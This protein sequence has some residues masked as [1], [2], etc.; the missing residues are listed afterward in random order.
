MA[1]TKS[2]Y[3]KAL[4]LLTLSLL[5]VAQA[6]RAEIQALQAQHASELARQQASHL[7]LTR[8]LAADAGKELQRALGAAE[9]REAE[10]KAAAEAHAE[11]AAVS[12]AR[13]LSEAQLLVTSLTEAKAAAEASIAGLREELSGMRLQQE[14]LV[15]ENSRAAEASAATVA[16]LEATLG[17]RVGQREEQLQEERATAAKE[18]N[19]ALEAREVAVTQLSGLSAQL[20]AAL[21][22]ASESASSQL[23]LQEAL[24]LKQGAYDELEA[25]WRQVQEALQQ[26]GSAGGE[27]GMLTAFE[28]TPAAAAANESNPLAVSGPLAPVLQR[29]ASSQR[30]LQQQQARCMQLE[31][32]LADATAAASMAAAAKEALI[33]A[34]EARLAEVSGRGCGCCTAVQLYIYSCSFVLY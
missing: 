9:G 29:L 2:D 7:A 19:Q 13:Q 23:A 24:A 15:S 18:L 32:G 21:L 22:A 20:D 31:A 14:Q 1:L 4:P 28:T 11:A 17:A 8:Q 33:G 27:E 10:A 16:G 3:C 12:S 25:S 34:L 6:V 30:S 5:S 26:L